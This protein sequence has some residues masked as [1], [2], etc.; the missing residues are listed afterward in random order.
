MRKLRYILGRIFEINYK[1]IWEL[2]GKVQ[3]KNHKNKILILIDMIYCSFKYQAAFHDYYCFGMYDLNKKE[4]LTILTRGKNNSYVRMLNPKEYWH[5]FD[6]KNEFNSLFDDY[7]KR[8]W[9]YLEGV[10]LEGFKKWISNLDEI[11]AKPNNDS[12]GHGIEK[13]EVNHKKLDELYDYLL[14]KKLLLIEEVIKQHED[15]SKVYSKSINTIR[16]ITVSNNDKV[17]FLTAFLRIGNGSFVDNTSSGGML[18]MV[19]LDTGVTMYPACDNNL[20]IY[21][22]HP[23]TFVPIKGIKVPYFEEIKT[24]VTKLA[25]VVPE[26][27]YIAW[28]IALGCDGPVVVEGNPYPGYY[29]QY[30]VHTPDKKGVLPRFNEILNDKN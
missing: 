8:K 16:I 15:L 21:E 2:V 20:N 30:P 1:K 29:Y 4:R 7:L 9:L 23:I 6:N 26:V 14:N 12:G 17:S 25:F 28:D 27:R 11:I 24:L 18:T 3:E 19:D 13:I 10:S 5:F 22:K